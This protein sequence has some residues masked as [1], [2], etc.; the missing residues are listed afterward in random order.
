MLGPTYFYIFIFFYKNIY[1]YLF[2]DL[3]RIEF[4]A[5]FKMHAHNVVELTGTMTLSPSA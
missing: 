4:H 3:F 5:V 1:F 2:A